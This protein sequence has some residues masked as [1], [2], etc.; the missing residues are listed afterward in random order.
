VAATRIDCKFLAQSLGIKRTH[1]EAALFV[2]LAE[3]AF[4][5]QDFLFGLSLKLCVGRPAHDLPILHDLHFKFNAFVF[6]GTARIPSI[7][8]KTENFVFVQFGIVGCVRF[9]SCGR[10]AAPGY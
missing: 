5:F 9:N 4:Q 3:F 10:G 7:I 2:A 8:Y 1:T 6:D